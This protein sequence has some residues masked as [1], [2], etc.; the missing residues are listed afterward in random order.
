M[1]KT[2]TLFMLCAALITFG[3]DTDFN[4]L[5]LGLNVGG[6]DGH[7]P[8]RLG[9]PK[10]YQPHMVRGNIRYMFNNRIGVMGSMQYNNFKIGETGYRTNYISNQIH[11]VVN[12]GDMI[13][14]HTVHEN[15]GLLIH[16]GVGIASMW[17]RGFHDSL[18][19]ENPQSPLWNRSDDMVVWSFGF[20]P[21]YRIGD[22]FAINADL[23][24]NFHAR[25][26]RTFD[27]QHRNRRSGI[28]GY[29][30]T[31]S[32]GA[33][34][35]IGSNAK[36]ADWTP[37]TYGSSVDMSSYDE[38]V[39]QLEREY[40][41]KLKAMEEAMKVEDADGD[42]VPDE[43][44]LCPDKAGPWGFSGCPDTDG[45]GIPDHIDQ[46]PDVYGSWKYQGC[47]KPSREVKEAL[48][49]GLKGVNFETGRAVLTSDSYPA[50][51][52]VVEVMKADNTYKLKITGHTDNVGTLEHNM[53]LSKDRAQAVEDY[54]E[55]KGLDADR[56][57]VIGFGPTRPVAS[58]D[59][60]EGKAKNRRVEFTVVY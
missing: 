32:V 21:Q 30:L 13:K 35:Y 24:F 25:Q 34:Y 4:K 59:T 57:I 20:N 5:S 55:S 47:P 15:L 51:D 43:Y 31:L 50:L 18:G 52:A 17:Q 36:H 7:A 48:D 14:L 9:R 12:A 26:S 22:R 29:F 2:L 16:G 37:T 56:F 1:K 23:I 33:S 46:C 38:R 49:K 58:N 60:P 8:I 27:F 6:S 28:D 41:E 54:L 39:K 19:I 11:L 42:G 53:K 44:D 40:N 10:L 45:D 3:Q